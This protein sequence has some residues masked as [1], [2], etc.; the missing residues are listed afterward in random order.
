MA[1]RADTPRDLLYRS[2][3]EHVLQEVHI[4]EL[5]R[6]DAGAIR[7]WRLVDAN[8]TALGAWGRDLRDVVGRT[9]EEIFVGGDPIETFLPIVSAIFESGEPHEWEGFF[10]GTGQVLHMVSVPVGGYFVST[11]FDVTEIR[12]QERALQDALHNLEEAIEAGGVGLWDWDLITNEITY[13][14]K[15]KQQLGYAPHEIADAY[16]AWESR[17]HPDDLDQALASIQ[18]AIREGEEYSETMFRMR[19]KDGSWRWIIAHGAVTRDDDGT[20]VRMQGSHLDVTE[21]RKL[22]ARVEESQRLDAIGTLAAGIAHDFN[23]LLTAISGNLSLFSHIQGLP[24]HAMSLARDIES[25][26]ERAQS[27]TN[28]LLTFSKGGHPVREV[29]SIDRL[30]VDS[31]TFVARGSGST[32]RFR[33]ADGLPHV[34][35]DVGQISQVVSN[36]VINATQAMPDGGIIEVRGSREV[37][38]TNNPLGLDAGAYV[39]FSVQDEGA[40]IPESIISRIFD[41]FY[42]TKPEG[43]GLGLATSYSIVERHGGRLTVESEVGQGARFDVYLPVSDAPA[44]PRRDTRDE[45]QRGEGRILVMDDDGPVLVAMERM[46]DF[47]GYGC[48]VASDGDEAAARYAD[49]LR[50]GTPYRAVILDLVIPGKPGGLQVLDRLRELDPDVTAIVASGYTD[51]DIL[52]DP[53]AH[54]FQGRLRKPI[55]ASGLGAELAR[56]LRAASGS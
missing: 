50:T 42:T 12:Q 7:T 2:L 9:T 34:E 26:T 17:V 5:V 55:R 45:V 37:L 19:H 54:G 16:E 18:A 14:D 28:Q 49:A 23:N 8:P 51:S 40:G 4:W 1:G 13:S 56:V 29:M 30:V 3:F 52:A 43:S 31:A 22:Q 11:G 20:A 21:R 10:P 32:C 53:E 33:I 24:S 35:V 44:A 47:L 27:L 48:D 39:R 25:A 46:L 38:G 15:W 6:D 41:P 36:L